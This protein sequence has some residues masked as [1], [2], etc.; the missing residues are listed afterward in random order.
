MPGRLRV[1]V[2]RLEQNV[3]LAPYTTWRIGGAASYL[4]RPKTQAEFLAALEFAS[5]EH[6]PSVVMGRGSNVLVPDEGISGLVILLR[7]SMNCL[8]VDDVAGRITAEAGVPLPTLAAVA[9]SHG[10][11]GFE[12]MIGIPGSVGAAVAINAGVGGIGGE[13]VCDRLVSAT[14]VSAGSNVPTEL[15]A[16]ALAAGYRTTLILGKGIFILE[17]VFAATGRGDPAEIGVAHQL[18]RAHRSKTQPSGRR[19]SGSVFKSVTGGRPAGWYIELSGLKGL[20]VGGAIVSEKHA[21]W[22]ENSGDATADDVVR[23]MAIMS[24]RV[25]VGFGVALEPEIRDLAADLT[26]G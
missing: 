1:T 12:F 6:L 7:N 9:R 23:L 8:H 2:A 17:A 5:E 22:I 16:D 25:L 13:S 21:N 14:V 11:L 15:A 4:L 26:I 20:R 24:E 19:T 10:L 18:V 3:V